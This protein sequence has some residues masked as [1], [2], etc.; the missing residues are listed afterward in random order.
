MNAFATLGLL[1]ILG[2]V[3]VVGSVAISIFQW[4]R[5]SWSQRLGPVCVFVGLLAVLL[6]V[7]RLPIAALVWHLD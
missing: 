3:L 1:S 2:W 4:K 7:D 5:L 6:F